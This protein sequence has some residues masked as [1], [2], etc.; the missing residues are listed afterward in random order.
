MPDQ[1]PR[2]PLVGADDPFASSFATSYAGVVSFLAVANEGSFARAG[3]R[4]GIGRSS[5]SRN[6]QKLEAQLDARLFL[7]TTRSTSLTREGELFYENCQP[8]IARIAQALEDMRE[9]RNGPPRGHLRIASTPGFGR[10]I[11]APLLRGFHA[12]YPEI[13]LELLLN[14]R[15][16]D[17]TADRV[18]VSFRDGRMEDSGIVAR[19]LIPMQMLVCASPAYARVHGLPRHI[20]ELDKHRCIN[21]RAASGRIREWAFK[22]DGL[23]QRRQ[24]AAQHTFNDPDLI[25]QAVLDGL[26]IAQLPAYQVCDLL[27]DGQLLSC[28]AQHAPDDGGHYLCYLS[29]KQLPARVRVFIDYMT[30]HTRALD[31]QCL[32]TMA[33]TTATTT[34]LSTVE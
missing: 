12:G 25:V 31:L 26:G 33:M 27:R 24:L 9:L 17:F 5:V 6:V 19:Q 16:A 3:D 29:R 30:E 10:K 7:R 20:D 22:V 34:T 28:L 32:T 11:V 18:D 4:L 21:F 8:G 1:S 2:R 14:D 23:S 13:A 15:P